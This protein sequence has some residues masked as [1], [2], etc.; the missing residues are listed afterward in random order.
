MADYLTTKRFVADFHIHTA[1]SPCCRNE[2]TP[3]AIIDAAVSCGIDMLAV[4]DHNSGNNVLAVEQLAVAAGIALF[5]SLE[6]HVC[7]NFH[8]LTLF[9]DFLKYSE[10]L[11]YVKKHRSK[12][13]LDTNSG[14][15]QHIINAHDDILGAI[16]ERLNLDTDI[17]VRAAIELV[18]SLGGICI[19]SHIDRAVDS[20]YLAFGNSIPRDLDFDALEISSETSIQDALLEYAD[21]AER[22]PFVTHSD[23]HNLEEFVRGRRTVYYLMNKPTLAEIKLALAGKDGRRIEHIEKSS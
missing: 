22:Y 14:R 18:H 23:A 4:S 6:L 17:P 2:M 9:D 12:T 8:M 1:L 7:E 3:K 21:L 16:T 11:G 19:A 10:W 5:Y 20:A 13:Q 15:A